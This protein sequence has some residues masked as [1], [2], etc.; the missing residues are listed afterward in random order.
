MSLR[1]DAGEPTE[2]EPGDLSVLQLLLRDGRTDGQP[3]GE[4]P[5]GEADEAVA[6]RDNPLAH[7]ARLPTGRGGWGAQ[8]AA[9]G[10]Q[11]AA[12][13]AR[14]V[15]KGLVGVMLDGQLEQAAGLLDQ[16]VDLGAEKGGRGGL[17]GLGCG[18]DLGGTLGGAYLIQGDVADGGAVDLQ[19][20]VA[21]VDG[22]L[23]VRADAVWIYPAGPAGSWGQPPSPTTVTGGGVLGHCP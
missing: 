20:A 11:G 4:S 16:Q 21:H 9:R 15:A 23:H 12:G 5:R 8:G 22:V 1:W 3:Q 18:A 13:K 2:L 6:L 19:Y 14:L 17:G 7:G 10:G